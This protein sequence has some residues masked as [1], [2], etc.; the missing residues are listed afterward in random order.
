MSVDIP[1][2]ILNIVEREIK[3]L[4]KKYGI[5]YEYLVD[6]LV[7]KYT[8][9]SIQ[10]LDAT[11]RDKWLLA[12]RA[13]KVDLR[14]RSSGGENYTVV[15]F[16]IMQ[17]KN[18]A[19]LYAL[20][21]E[22]D[23][24]DD[25]NPAVISF[26]GFQIKN[27]SKIQLLRKYNNVKLRKTTNV[28]RYSLVVDTK[29]DL[30]SSEDLPIA[31]TKEDFYH[32]FLPKKG[33]NI[34]KIKISDIAN[35]NV[36]S[37]VDNSSGFADLWDLRSVTGWVVN[38]SRRFFRIRVDD[39]SLEDDVFINLESENK[40][41]IVR[42]SLSVQVHESFLSELDRLMKVTVIGTLSMVK[43]RTDEEESSDVEYYI[44]KMNS[45]V[46]I[47]HGLVHGY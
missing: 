47:N 13:L 43:L 5:Q 42:K 16:G 24:L 33:V 12:L 40:I 20:V 31:I 9:D 11:D 28:R 14:S 3:N 32:K 44:P 10:S 8:D 37:K 36:W 7:E 4:S 38:V 2:D 29:F 6:S 25:L 26:S 39:D 18:R 22:G 35:G 34:K 17:F 15:P 1:K 19:L 41:L 23:E 45:M 46:V 27:L 30:N 21:G